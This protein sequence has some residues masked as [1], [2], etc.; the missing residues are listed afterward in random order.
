MKN[1]IFSKTEQKHFAENILLTDLARDIEDKFYKSVKRRL[2]KLLDACLTKDDIEEL[3]NSLRPYPDCATKV[4]LFH[5]I[6]I[7]EKTIKN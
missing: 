4:F 2:I 1:I 3:K 6:I 5:A 7:K